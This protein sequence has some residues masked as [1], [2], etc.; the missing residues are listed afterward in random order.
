[1]AFLNS[2][3]QAKFLHNFTV[4]PWSGTECVTEEGKI[5]KMQRFCADDALSSARGTVTKTLENYTSGLF[6]HGA[7]GYHMT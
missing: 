7:N 3:C 4:F 6:C 2:T 5:R 1:M